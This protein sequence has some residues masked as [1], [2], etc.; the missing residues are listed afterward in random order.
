MKSATDQRGT[1]NQKIEQALPLK[2]H[3]ACQGNL[4]FPFTNPD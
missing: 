2:L 3:Q 4:N 1:A